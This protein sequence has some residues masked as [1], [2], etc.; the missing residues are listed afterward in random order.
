MSIVLSVLQ[1][2]GIMLLV[3]LGVLV[4]AILLVLFA[5][6]FYQI[7]GDIRENKW[8]KARISW[9]LHLLRGRIAY[10]DDL[11]YGELW[12]AWKKLTF[13]Y[14]LSKTDEKEKDKKEDKPKEKKSKGSFIDKIKSFVQWIKDNYPKLKRIVTD[15]RNKQAV[16]HL[17]NELFN[18]IKILLPKKSKLNAEFSTGSPDTTGQLCGAIAL[19]PVMYQK[20]WKLSPDFTAEEAYFKG[21]FRGKGRVCAFQLFGILLRIMFDKNCKRMYTMINKLKNSKKKKTF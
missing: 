7:E 11:V 4:V 13:S 17:K 6:F 21:D 8:I 3:L 1:I 19:F 9:L 18:L 15:E 5:P 12:I 16:V 10:E 2:L 14:D 20:D